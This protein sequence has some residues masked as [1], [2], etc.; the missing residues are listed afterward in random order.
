ML[1]PTPTKYT[2]GGVSCLLGKEEAYRTLYD[3]KARARSRKQSPPG[4]WPRVTASRGRPA[5]ASR[6]ASA[7]PDHKP[8]ELAGQE[9]R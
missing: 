4:L 3:V 2:D 8:L 6:A 9:G 5:S 7:G 1:L